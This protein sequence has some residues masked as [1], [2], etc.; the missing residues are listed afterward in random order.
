MTE[1]HQLSSRSAYDPESYLPNPFSLVHPA[2]SRIFPSTM[3]KVQPSPVLHPSTPSSTVKVQK[4][5]LGTLTAGSAGAPGMK[6][7]GVGVAKTL[8]AR[9]KTVM[10]K[11]E[12]MLVL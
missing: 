7:C 12:C 6:R 10:K 1:N 11:V 9:A 3:L 5:P 2:Q 8:A 4:V